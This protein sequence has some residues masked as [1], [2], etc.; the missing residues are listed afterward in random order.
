MYNSTSYN[1]Y[2]TF[3]NHHYLNDSMPFSLSSQ[4]QISSDNDD[5]SQSLGDA[6]NGMGFK[7]RSRAV[8]TEEKDAVY[9][10]KRARN[11]DSAKRSRDARRMKEQE[12]QDRVNFLEHENS[13]LV[14][15]NQAIRYQLSQLHT[16]YT[17]ISKPV[18]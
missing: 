7:K 18:Q 5:D 4:K 11:N 14:M 9:Y 8:P 6:S 17:G 2:P 3:F 10:E 13:R 15:E 1:A 16:I 12:I